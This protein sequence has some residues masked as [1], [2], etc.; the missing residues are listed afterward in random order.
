MHVNVAMATT[1][2]LAAPRY[3]VRRLKPPATV[4]AGS[5]CGGCFQSFAAAELS[6]C[7]ECGRTFFCS[8]S[9]EERA[10]GL[11]RPVCALFR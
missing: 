7:R 5:A 6:A 4:H 3:D 8:S 2:A 9:C 1:V 10:A 11:H